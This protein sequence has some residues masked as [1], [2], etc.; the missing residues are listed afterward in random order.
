[1]YYIE[2]QL[3]KISSS[4]LL[5]RDESLLLMSIYLAIVSIFLYKTSKTIKDYD[6]VCVNLDKLTLIW[7][8]TLYQE[9]AST[10]I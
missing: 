7:S 4:D 2:H 8:P 3:I 6:S 10:L 1:M 9:K 5:N